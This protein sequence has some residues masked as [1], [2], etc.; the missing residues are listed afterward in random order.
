MRVKEPAYTC[1]VQLPRAIGF[2]VTHVR[3]ENVLPAAWCGY[4][5]EMR[6]NPYEFQ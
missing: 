6:A 1:K 5:L 3:R 2:A 4:K